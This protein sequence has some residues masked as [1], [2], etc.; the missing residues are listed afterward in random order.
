MGMPVLL[1]SVLSGVYCVASLP[2]DAFL[3]FADGFGQDWCG[4]VEK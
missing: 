4:E 3:C 1:E 2:S